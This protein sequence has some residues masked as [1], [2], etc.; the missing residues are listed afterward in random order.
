MLIFLATLLVTVSSILRSRAALEL[1][2][3]AVRHRVGVLQRSVKKR[4]KFDST[5]SSVVG[6]AVPH[7]ERLALGAGH[8]L[9]GVWAQNSVTFRLSDSTPLQ[10]PA[11]L[12]SHFSCH[13]Q[14]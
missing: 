10:A 4:P 12:W 5:G 7:L 1:E 9:A 14:A 2:N 11:R 3:L 6:L 13:T 8:R